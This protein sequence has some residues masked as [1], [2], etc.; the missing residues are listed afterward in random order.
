[1]KPTIL[2]NLWIEN[3]TEQEQSLFKLLNPIGFKNKNNKLQDSMLECSVKKQSNSIQ[4]SNTKGT[5]N[6]EN[7]TLGGISP[8]FLWDKPFHG[9]IGFQLFRIIS[10]F[11]FVRNGAETGVP[12]FKCC[13]STDTKHLPNLSYQHMI[14]EC[15]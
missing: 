15:Y 11:L 10:F 14:S 5:K 1:M 12:L 7:Q 2:E 3:T 9:D 13:Y 4:E 8:K 6:Q